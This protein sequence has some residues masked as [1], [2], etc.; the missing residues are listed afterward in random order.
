[1]EPATGPAGFVDRREAHEREAREREARKREARE[2]EIQ[3]RKAREREARQREA[4]QGEV[5]EREARERTAREREARQREAREAEAREG[6]ARQ[7][8]AR[9][10]EARERQARGREA[11]ERE[12]RKREAREREAREREARRV[13]QAV[14]GPVGVGEPD[15]DDDQW[16]DD[17]WDRLQ[18]EGQDDEAPAGPPPAREARRFRGLA[19]PLVAAAVVAA[20]GYPLTALAVSRVRLPE[21]PGQEQSSA[22]GGGVGPR[23]RSPR[24]RL[25]GAVTYDGPARP[26]ECAGGTPI[27]VTYGAGEDQVAIRLGLPSLVEPGSY[28]VKGQDVFVAVTRLAGKGQTWST[29]NQPDAAG[30]LQVHPDRSLSAQFSGLKPTGG[31]GEDTVQGSLEMRCG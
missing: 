6:E 22:E 9:E 30:R 10:D 16:A 15:R 13:E 28:E 5:R 1:M 8:E 24:V 17:Q 20:I 3:G 2:R 31:A 11:S 12:A 25:S 26:I 27:L 18:E 19:V 29:R 23:G 14:G 7:R 4:R 21:T